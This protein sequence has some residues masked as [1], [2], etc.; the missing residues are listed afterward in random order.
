[1]LAL[2]RKFFKQTTILIS[3]VGCDR[4]QFEGNFNRI[5]GFYCRNRAGIPDSCS[6]DYF[7]HEYQASFKQSQFVTKRLGVAQNFVF[8]S[9]DNLGFVGNLS[10]YSWIKWFFF[11]ASVG[12][13]AL[14]GF[15][16]NIK[17]ETVF[18]SWRLNQFTESH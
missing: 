3:S 8:S 11:L 6:R 18:Q 16:F 15:L 13:L 2:H 5:R 14:G 10:W 1:M 17:R 4:L 9:G 7:I 12:L